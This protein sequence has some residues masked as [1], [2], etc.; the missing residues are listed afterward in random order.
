ML[1]EAGAIAASELSSAKTRTA[2][3]VPPWNNSIVAAVVWSIIAGIVIALLLASW[4]MDRS[5]KRR[6]AR[7]ADSRDIY[8]EVREG[9]RDSRTIDS[10]FLPPGGKDYTWTSW[11][12]RNRGDRQGP[13]ID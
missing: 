12:R 8:N 6:H 2:K 5:A 9:V 3:A 11:S 10:T 7:I 4:L 13:P 1:T